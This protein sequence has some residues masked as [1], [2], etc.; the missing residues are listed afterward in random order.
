MWQR[1]M[2]IIR[3]HD[4]VTRWCRLGG[5]SAYRGDSETDSPDELEDGDCSSSHHVLNRRRVQVGAVSPLVVL[6][7]W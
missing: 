2:S 7:S 3:V 4:E 1:D 6:E 5:G